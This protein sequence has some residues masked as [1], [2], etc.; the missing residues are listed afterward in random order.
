MSKP[1]VVTIPH[2]LGAAEARKRIE[3]G[4]GQ[5]AQQL[6]GGMAQ[7]HQSW[8]GDRLTFSADVMGQGVTGALDVR[9]DDVQ[10]EIYLPGFLA[11]IAN[12]IK[13]KLQKEGQVLLE[14]K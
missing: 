7:I 13:G 11:L 5:L 10:M 8:S 2:Q 9:Q 12:K 6:P 3:Q 14:K 4:L 1:V